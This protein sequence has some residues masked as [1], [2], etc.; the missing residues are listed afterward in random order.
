MKK[1]KLI[2]E[3]VKEPLGGAHR[4]R[5]ETFTT[6]SK[7]IADAY[8]EFK[9]LSPEELVEKRQEKYLNMGVFKA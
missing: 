5:E 7:A 1:Q 8:E 4:N 2:D 9:N 6:V 3:I